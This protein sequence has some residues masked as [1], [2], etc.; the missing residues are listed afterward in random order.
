MVKHAW[1]P[2]CFRSWG[3]GSFTSYANVLPP[4]CIHISDYIYSNGEHK[5]ALCNHLFILTGIC[6]EQPSVPHLIKIVSV[7]IYLLLNLYC[8]NLPNQSSQLHLIKHYEISIH[9]FLSE[10]LE[11]INL[12]Q[13]ES[14][15][16]IVSPKWTFYTVVI[17]FFLFF[18]ILCSSDVLCYEIPFDTNEQLSALSCDH[19]Q[20]SRTISLHQLSEL[21]RTIK[22][23]QARTIWL[24]SRTW[25]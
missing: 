25:W 14:I 24:S 2:M 19:D 23:S 17:G 11:D 3:F 22:S 10:Q 16:L 18:Y 1:S 13:S 15:L 5:V 7:R 6:V 4:S 9:S 12:D 20:W 8:T 21:C